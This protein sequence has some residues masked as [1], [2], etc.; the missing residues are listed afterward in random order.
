M[1][2]CL[3]RST[4]T[5]FRYNQ[6]Q[7]VQRMVF[8]SRPTWYDH[9]TSGGRSNFMEFK[10]SKTGADVRVWGGHCWRVAFSKQILDTNFS[11]ILISWTFLSILV[12][13]ICLVGRISARAVLATLQGVRSTET[14]WM[15]H[16]WIYLE[17]CRFQNKSRYLHSKAFLFHSRFNCLSFSSITNDTLSIHTSGRQ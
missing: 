9:S 4:G 2:V 5:I 11:G 14:L 17:F 10:A 7:S 15:V 12:A 16:R 8:K 1:K 3:F 6:L 13:C